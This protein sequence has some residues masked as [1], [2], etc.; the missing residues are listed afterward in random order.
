MKFD[1]DKKAKSE[2][3]AAFSLLSQIGVTMA[4][5][6]GGSVLLGVWLDGKL[7]TAPLFL[8]L[9][10]VF[11]FGGA[12]KSLFVMTRRFSNGAGKKK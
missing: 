6:I 11:G 1:S 3:L 2:I 7:H 4:V 8:L 9:F 5:C 10:V 12:I